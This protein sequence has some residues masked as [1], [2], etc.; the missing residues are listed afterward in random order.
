MKRGI[1]NG[2]ATRVGSVIEAESDQAELDE[3]IDRHEEKRKYESVLDHGR[4]FLCLSTPLRNGNHCTRKTQ[5]PRK[6]T[7]KGMAVYLKST[8]AV[9]VV[10]TCT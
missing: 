8:E 9:A 2:G 4:A 1:T 5:T 7:D 3:A 10:T 6:G